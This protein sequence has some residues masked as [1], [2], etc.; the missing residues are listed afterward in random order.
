MKP[1]RESKIPLA[2]QLCIL[3]RQFRSTREEQQR[4]FIAEAY[5]EAVDQLIES[6]KWRR[7][8]SLEDQLPD[9]WMPEAFLNT[10]HLAPRCAGQGDTNRILA[11]NTIIFPCSC[12]TPA[13]GPSIP[14]CR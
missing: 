8:P 10:G 7:I 3:A 5:A 12:G 6:K 9:E 2:K 4:V 1:K 13:S 14:E 11:N